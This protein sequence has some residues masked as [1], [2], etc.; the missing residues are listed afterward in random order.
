MDS[1]NSED[2]EMSNTP[3]PITLVSDF[4][5]FPTELLNSVSLLESLYIISINLAFH[6][7][8]AS[9]HVI[10]ENMG[11][12]KGYSIIYL[13]FSPALFSFTMYKQASF[14][15]L[16]ALASAVYAQTPTH[17]PLATATVENLGFVSDPASNAYGIFHDGG[18]GASQNGYHVQVFADSDT[19]SNGF[20]FVHNSVAYYGFV[21]RYFFQPNQVKLTNI[22]A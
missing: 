13:S 18:G 21:S 4:K 14:L 2:A 5:G 7:I 10:I 16:S 19:T 3:F 12:L 17:V 11:D 8:P 9:Y 15:L 20:N 1:T 22:Q 6:L